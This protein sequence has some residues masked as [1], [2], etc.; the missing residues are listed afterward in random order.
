MWLC[1]RFLLWKPDSCGQRPGSLLPQGAVSAI[2]GPGPPGKG[3]VLQS[4]LDSGLRNPRR[5]QRSVV[6]GCVGG[7]HAGRRKP[8][9][10]CSGY[11]EGSP[12]SEPQLGSDSPRE[13]QGLFF[14]L[15]HFLSLSL[16]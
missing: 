11:G 12:G 16:K 15:A 1:L 10:V 2:T 8:A 3:D 14:L 9:P 4:G 7:V 13:L 6:T 5:P